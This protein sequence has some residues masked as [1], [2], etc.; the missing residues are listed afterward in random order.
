[1]YLSGPQVTDAGLAYLITGLPALTSLTLFFSE[2]TDTGVAKLHRA[3]PNCAVHWPI[4]G[5]G[6]YPQGYDPRPR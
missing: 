5:F 2:V 3:L 1:M 6:P 4:P